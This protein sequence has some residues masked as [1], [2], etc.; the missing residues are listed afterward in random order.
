MSLGRL[1]SDHKGITAKVPAESRSRGHFHRLETKQ[2]KACTLR[3][4]FS[5]LGF[6]RKKAL[7]NFTNNECSGSS[8]GAV[9]I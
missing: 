5:T 7:T 6:G 2:L 4:G 1:F 3:E 9:V 8:R